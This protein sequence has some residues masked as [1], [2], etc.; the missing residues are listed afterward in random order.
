[1]GRGLCG[2]HYKRASRAGTLHLWPLVGHLTNE[3]IEPTPHTAYTVEAADMII[4]TARPLR[5]DS[6][7]AAAARNRARV[8]LHAS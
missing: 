4:A 8:L 7:E 5:V 3:E 6:Y 2:L 1:M